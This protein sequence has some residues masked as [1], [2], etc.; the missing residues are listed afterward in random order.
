VY[1]VEVRVTLPEAV[2]GLR[3]ATAHLKVRASARHYRLTVLGRVAATG[4]LKPV[5]GEERPLALATVDVPSAEEF[6]A[7]G[8]TYVFVLE[9]R[10]LRGGGDENLA[11]G[12]TFE[13]ADVDLEG[14]TR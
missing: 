3:D 2:G 13:G 8:G 11:I 12:D 1:G 14:T 7:P 5:G 9:F 4:V 10:R 6:A